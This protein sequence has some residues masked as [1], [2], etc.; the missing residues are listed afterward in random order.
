M[1]LP[2][3][4]VHDVCSTYQI[5]A[6]ISNE[7]FKKMIIAMARNIRRTRRDIRDMMSE[8]DLPKRLIAI[9]RSANPSVWKI[10]AAGCRELRAQERAAKSANPSPA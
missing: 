2:F 4:Q 9:E 3:S 8:P 1:T 5:A 10:L 7:R 6:E